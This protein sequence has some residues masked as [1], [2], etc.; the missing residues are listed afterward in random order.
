MIGRIL[1]K[2]EWEVR[3]VMVT[4]TNRESIN[5]SRHRREDIRWDRYMS[6]PR[7]DIINANIILK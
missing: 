3:I 7:K 5:P 6:R 2:V 1:V 4:K